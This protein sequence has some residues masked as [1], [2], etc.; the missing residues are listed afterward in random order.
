MVILGIDPG[1]ERLGWGIIKKEKAF[2]FV[3]CG[4]IRTSSRE[5]TASRLF[6]AAEELKVIIGRYQPTHAAVESLFVFKNQKTVIQ[7]A[8]A[9]GMILTCLA[10]A[11]LSISEFT[12]LQ[13]KS[14]VAGDGQA[15]KKSVEKMV[16]LQLP[17]VPS[18]LLDDTLDA[19]AAALALACQ[20]IYV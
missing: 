8:Q 1:Y 18:G 10:D 15:D 4:V 16:R 6:H 20:N 19:L 11:S 13:I 9:R 5:A 3:D 12:P 17:A 7:V 14:I 2:E